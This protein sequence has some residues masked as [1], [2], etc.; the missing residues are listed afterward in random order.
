M[1]TSTK[2]F[3][4]SD[5]K[6]IVSSCISVFFLVIS[7]MYSFIPPSYLYSS[8]KDFVS[9]V[10]LIFIPLFKKASSLNL[11]LKRSELYFVNV[12]YFLLGLNDIFVPF[13]SVFPAIFRGAT[14]LLSLYSCV[15]I[16]PFLY[17]VSSRDSDR[18]L[19]TDTPT[20]CNPPD[21]L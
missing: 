13:K 4:D 16:E 2:I 8:F 15:W 19:T 9:S 21:T 5:L 20:P 18:A 17:I 6:Y 14:G 11:L 12:K 10:N 7:F 3:L 1:A